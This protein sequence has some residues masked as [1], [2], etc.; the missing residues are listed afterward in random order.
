MTNEEEEEDRRRTK[1]PGCP[2]CCPCGGSWRHRVGSRRLRSG[3][4]RRRLEPSWA[5]EPWGKKMWY[6]LMPR[7]S[8]HQSGSSNNKMSYMFMPRNSPHH[9]V[10]SIMRAQTL[11]SPNAGNSVAYV[12]CAICAKC[13][14]RQKYIDV[15]ENWPA[16]P[17][18]SLVP[19]VWVPIVHYC[20]FQGERGPRW[21][22]ST[23]KWTLLLLIL[24]LLHKCAIA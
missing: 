11:S 1:A 23:P 19:L 3:M 7:N 2:S 16:Y 13:I 4:K 21:R 5:R 20:W 22:L 6:M 17:T 10:S 8:P 24:F 18:L 15:Y 12:Q 14:C 9:S